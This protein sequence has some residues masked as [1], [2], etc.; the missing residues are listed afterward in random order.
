MSSADSGSHEVQLNKV[1]KK[2]SIESTLTN[3][4]SLERR[5]AGMGQDKNMHL[6]S[7]VNNMLYRN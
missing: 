2:G 4:N 5:A 7:R 3:K 6:E 1:L